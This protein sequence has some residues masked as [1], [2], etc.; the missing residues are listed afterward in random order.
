MKG[1]VAECR[2]DSLLARHDVA[3]ILVQRPALSASMFA[4]I[5][6]IPCIL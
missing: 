4:I 1:N 2:T 5:N 3:N 6:H